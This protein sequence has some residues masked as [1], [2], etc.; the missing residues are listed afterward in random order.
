MN[1][2]PV[3]ADWYVA[4]EVGLTITGDPTLEQIDEELAMWNVVS[5][6]SKWAIADLVKF[7]Y[8]KYGEEEAYGMVSLATRY[9][10]NYLYN[11]VMVSNKVAPAQRRSL[12]NTGMTFTHHQAV[13]PLSPELQ[14]A[15]L[16]YATEK[17]QTRDELR[18]GIQEHG[19]PPT[20]VLP[21]PKQV[22]I[23]VKP[24]LEESVIRYVRA[25]K[26]GNSDLAGE[27]FLDLVLYVEHK[28]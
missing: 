9:H 16:D 19:T 10:K 7:A 12:N 26:R 5:E 2:L 23:E 14:D 17:Q 13:A 15:W 1:T 21:M 28:L 6:L 27:Y 22:V 8:E 11:I 20:N 3:L 25:V 24:T 4:T 18:D